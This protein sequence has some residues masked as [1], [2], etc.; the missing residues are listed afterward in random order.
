MLSGVA[1]TVLQDSDGESREMF[2]IRGSRLNSS[3]LE[4]E[5]VDGPDTGDG[6]GVSEGDAILI[7]TPLFQTN[8]LP[9]FIHV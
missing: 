7:G 6:L 9:D 1:S 2:E 5:L 3:I 4:V 8:F